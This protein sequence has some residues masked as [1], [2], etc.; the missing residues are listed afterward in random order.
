MTNR[1]IR[2][3]QAQLKQLRRALLRLPQYLSGDDYMNGTSAE[4]L[5]GTA[6]LVL[7]RI[8]EDLEA[9]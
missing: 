3:V 9:K 2:E 4:G 8:A 1:S 6:I 5:V 7:D